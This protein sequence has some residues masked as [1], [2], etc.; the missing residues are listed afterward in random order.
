MGRE[1]GRGCTNFKRYNGTCV[2][3]LRDKPRS[4]LIN[5]SQQN[6]ASVLAVPYIPVSTHFN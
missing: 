6:G 2:S 3:D 4:Y 5:T 1:G